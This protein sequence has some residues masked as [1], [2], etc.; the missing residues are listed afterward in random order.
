ML[1]LFLLAELEFRIHTES[2]ETK[3]LC[4]VTRRASGCGTQSSAVRTHPTAASGACSEDPAAW[5]APRCF[6]WHPGSDWPAFCTD[7]ARRSLGHLFTHL[8]LPSV[9]RALTGPPRAETRCVSSS[10]AAER[11][12]RAR[13]FPATSLTLALCVLLPESH[14]ARASPSGTA[15]GQVR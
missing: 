10:T 1:A 8:N 14:N 9:S 7:S 6:R 15:A 11:S 4:R 2:Q 5:G 3:G 13:P 12:E